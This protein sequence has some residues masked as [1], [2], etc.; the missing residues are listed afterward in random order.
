MLT[1]ICLLSLGM[2]T[3]KILVIKN[4]K[5]PLLHRICSNF[6]QPYNYLVVVHL[7]K[8]R[9]PRLTSKLGNGRN[10]KCEKNLNFT[11]L[12]HCSVGTQT[13]LETHITRGKVHLICEVV[14]YWTKFKIKT[15]F[16]IV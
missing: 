9:L 14:D 7:Q 12:F 1:C 16:I 11:L 2:S 4:F 6:T 3:A 5:L 13:N 8:G 10:F 15:L